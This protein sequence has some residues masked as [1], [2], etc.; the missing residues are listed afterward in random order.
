MKLT[1]GFVLQSYCFPF[2]VQ[3]V[4]GQ[5]ATVGPLKDQH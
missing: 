5:V 1:I 2:G 4:T 3:M